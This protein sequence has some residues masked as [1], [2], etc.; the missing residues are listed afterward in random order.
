MIRTKDIFMN[1]ERIEEH[2]RS[3]LTEIGEDPHRQGLKDTPK[4]VA[5][6]YTEIFRRYHNTPPKLTAF[7]DETPRGLIMDSGYYFSMCEHHMIPFFGFYYFGYIP[8]QAYIG[9]SK[10]GRTVDHF[11]ARLQTAECLVREILDH[12]EEGIH[13]L[14]SILLM[15]GRHLCKEMRGLRK[16]N[17]PFEVIEA[18]GILLQNKDGCKDEFIAR[19]SSRI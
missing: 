5:K 19:L 14:G 12:I 10:I 7:S 4:R 3:I 15:N 8:D 17:S 16:W 6:M 18:R 9:A 13:P 2:I 1:N 11:A